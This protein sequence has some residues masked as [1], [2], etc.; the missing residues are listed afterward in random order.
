MTGSTRRLNHRVKIVY[1]ECHHQVALLW[2]L[3]T[4]L[5]LLDE[6]NRG[7]GFEVGQGLYNVFARSLVVKVQLLLDLMKKPV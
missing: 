5:Y 6:L 3:Y 1:I 7:I 4:V 2:T